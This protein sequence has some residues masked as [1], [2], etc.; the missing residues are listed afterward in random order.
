MGLQF[1]TIRGTWATW[2]ELFESAAAAASNAGPARLIG[3]S[4]S[5]DDNEG[6]ITVWYWEEPVLPKPAAGQ[7]RFRLFRG[8]WATWQTLFADA[9]AFAAEIGPARLIGLSHSE[10]KDDGLVTVWYW[11]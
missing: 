6:V 7:V 2:H 11:E 10:F 1:E 3:L 4:H 8:G 5:E 9:G